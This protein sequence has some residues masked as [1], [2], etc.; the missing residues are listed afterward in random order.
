MTPFN[1]P[2]QVSFYKGKVR[3][4]YYLSDN[5]LVMVASNR[6]S[7]FDVILPRTIPYKG[8]VLN[9]IAAYMLNATKDICPNWLLSIPAPNVAI[10]KKCTPFK[11]EMVVRGNLTGHAWRTYRS[12]KR[13]LC[14]ALLP[15]NMIENDFF[16]YPII[17]PSTK[18]SEG[19]DEDISPVE[20]IQQGLATQK[21]WDTLCQYTLALFERGKK[22]AA[23]QGLILVDTK[24]DFGKIGDEIVLMDEIHTPDSSRY[25]Y[26]DGF[27]QRQKNGEKQKQLSKEFVREWLIEN[28]FM[29]KEGQSIPLM[30]DEWIDTI[31][32][33][34]IELYEKVIG[35]K[36]IPQKLSEQETYN[37]IVASL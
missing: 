31:S 33:R 14:G 15:E 10:G 29:G 11:L 5:L 6:I 25:F 26:A 17:T 35:E 37:K 2:K 24:Y 12:G 21:E 23:K 36:F 3:D 8:Q 22:I 27:E 4:V 9:Q 28:N 19:H 18:A 1:F 32:N 30:T 7:A 20:I 34:Y 13:T 16:S